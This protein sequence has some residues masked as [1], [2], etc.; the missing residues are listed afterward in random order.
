MIDNFSDDYKFLSNFYFVNV[1]LADDKL[2]YPSTEHAYQ[3]A[4]TFDP[5]KRLEIRNAKSCGDAKRLGRQLVLRDD[6][7]KVK[8]KIM[9]DLLHIKFSYYDLE[10]KLLETGNQKLVEGNTW[11]DNF[12][13]VCTCISCNQER[14]KENPK[15]GEN[16]LGKLLMLVRLEIQIHRGI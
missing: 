10:K 4:K 15:L 2:V 13:G 1:Y 9:L 7:D 11:H 12:W 6:W 3:A 14:A 5:E 16:W 8:R